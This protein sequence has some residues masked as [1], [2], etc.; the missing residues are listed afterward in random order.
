MTKIL[1]VLD[2]FGLAETSQNNV[3]SMA[4]MPNIRYLLKNYWWTTL[5]SDGDCVGQESGLVG[6]SEVGHMNLGGLGL[7]KQ[8]SYQITKSSEEN[9]TLNKAWPDQI[10]DPK[11]FLKMKLSKSQSKT[12]HLVGLFSTGTIHSDLRHWAASIASAGL[13]GAEKIVLHIITDG[14][15]SDRTSL[16]S[17]WNYFTNTFEN[18]LKPYQDKIFLGSVGGRF[19]TMDR[20]NNWGRVIEGMAAMFDFSKLENVNEYLL[21]EYKIQN[22][23]HPTEKLKS[24]LIDLKSI[25]LELKQVCSLNYNDNKFDEMISA[26]G[27]FYIQKTDTVWL[28]NFRTDRMKEFS[29]VLCHLNQEF[30]LN[31]TILANNS[32]GIEQEIFLKSNLDIS[33]KIIP[34][35]FN[36]E[37]FK[38]GQYYPIFKNQAV[39]NPMSSVLSSE[40]KTQLH[41]AETEK[42]NHVT[43]FFNGGQNKKWEGETWHVINSNKVHSH[44][45]KPEMKAKEITD[46]IL[47]NGLGKYDYIIVNYANPD[48]LG[49][50][51]NI[52]ASIESMEA[53]DVEIGRLVKAVEK[54]N[55]KM[56]I[57]ADHGNIEMVGLTSGGKT[58]DTEHNANPVPCILVDGS[59][60]AKKLIQNI[61]E[62]SNQFNLKPNQEII[63]KVLEGEDNRINLENPQTWLE[64]NNIPKPQWPLWYAGLVLLGM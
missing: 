2:G 35:N 48:M 58:T 16:V 39:S 34:K 25:D 28:M 1:C 12:V 46:Y 57:T 64:K 21:S 56:L 4:K 60:D 47:E 41:I 6:N 55:H 7:I 26:V 61:L 24:E 5:N 14:R 29:T 33:S 38:E 20:D 62:L 54:G 13:S 19:Y 36:P 9:F 59:F 8:L 10:F 23:I 37:T 40:G 27:Y 51:G 45:E 49:H 30:N 42:Y 52:P 18:Q 17:T 31:L 22:E 43:Y 50:T 3:V 11:L 15:D 32:Y 63:Q 53:L 44:A